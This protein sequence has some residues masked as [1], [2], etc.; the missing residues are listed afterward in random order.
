MLWGE[1][2]SY[3]SFHKRYNEIKSFLMWHS[4]SYT[5]LFSLVFVL[6][7]YFSS[8]FSSNFDL[9]NLSLETGIFICFNRMTKIIRNLHQKAYRLVIAGWYI[10]TVVDAMNGFWKPCHVFSKS[11]THYIATGFLWHEV[12]NDWV[13]KVIVIFLNRLSIHSFV[14]HF[15]I[16]TELRCF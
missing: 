16:W 6:D 15:E 3:F 4:E 10:F 12:G 5:S 14:R 2:K 13:Y 11:V 7:G 8:P 1:V 9:S